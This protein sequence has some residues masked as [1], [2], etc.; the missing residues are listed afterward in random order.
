MNEHLGRKRQHGYQP[1]RTKGVDLSSL[2]C[3][4]HRLPNH[5]EFETNHSDR[6]QFIQKPIKCA[7]GASWANSKSA[8]HLPGMLAR[9]LPR[10]H[11]S[12]S[13]PRR[14]PAEVQVA[15]PSGK[16]KGEW[17]RS[18]LTY[19]SS[20][21]DHGVRTT[22]WGRSALERGP[23]AKTLGY[24]LPIR[25]RFLCIRKIALKTC[26]RTDSDRILG[27][28]CSVK[29]S[30]RRLQL[31]S[32]PLCSSSDNTTTVYQSP[33]SASVPKTCASQIDQSTLYPSLFPELIGHITRFKKPRI[34][35][36]SSP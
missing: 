12:L 18:M 36:I 11:P 1:L 35:T 6:E 2:K 5:S 34:P 9:S 30:L 21:L 17:G 13:R 22:E 26:D 20:F 31:R 24:T 23:Q 15:T 3:G 8:L 33:S 10:G 28:I 27:V 25:T 29:S 32:C 14:Q 19:I 7:K 16:C 4:C